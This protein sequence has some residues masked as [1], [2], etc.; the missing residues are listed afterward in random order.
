MLKLFYLFI[1]ILILGTNCSAQIEP[2]SA[3]I[4]LAN[5]S[6]AKSVNLFSIYSNPAA[7]SFERQRSFGIYY[8]P[9]PFGLSE[10]SNANAAYLEP[11]N[12]GNFAASFKTYGF[13]LYK[14]TSF[15]LT[16]SNNFEKFHYGIKLDYQNY[17]IKNYGNKNIFIA[18]AGIIYDISKS[19]NFGFSIR[20]LNHASLNESTLPVIYKTGISFAP[21]N[22]ML[23]HIAIEKETSQNLSPRI[24]I[25]YSPIKYISIRSGFRLE[26]DSFCS[27]IGIN[28]SLFSLNYS[29]FTHQFLPITH[30]F[31]FIT[32]F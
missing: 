21:I 31:G 26:P 6:I 15:G 25:E 16:Y 11:T 30:S 27:G 20:N 14:E 24:G 22:K 10:L 4:A 12:Y 13:E 1:F 23:I 28:Y 18:N 5:S 29:I 3:Q 2:A 9:S 32:K 19:L 17:S 7:A 8:S